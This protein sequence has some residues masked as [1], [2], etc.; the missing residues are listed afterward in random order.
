MKLLRGERARRIL[1]NIIMSNRIDHEDHIYNWIEEYIVQ[2]ADY[3][4]TSSEAN[5]VASLK[6]KEVNDGNIFLIIQAA[7]LLYS[8]RVSA[9]PKKVIF[10]RV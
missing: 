4:D 8:D 3:S 7:K 2:I 10:K 9:P 5:F 1:K 6:H